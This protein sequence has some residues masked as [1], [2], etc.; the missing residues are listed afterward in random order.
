[1]TGVYGLTTKEVA[2]KPKFPK[3]TFP[4]WNESRGTGLVAGPLSPG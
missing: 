4:V 2:G 1:M 3:V